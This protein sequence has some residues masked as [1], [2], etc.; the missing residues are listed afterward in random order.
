MAIPK[1]HYSDITTSYANKNEQG[2]LIIQSMI[3]MEQLAFAAFLTSFSQSFKSNWNQE[4]VY[5][6]ND[7][8]ATYQGTTRTIS[9]GFDIPAGTLLQAQNSL[10][11][12]DQLMKFLYPAYNN[13][14]HKRLQAAE[15]KNKKQ[16]K[17]VGAVISHAPLVKVRF[18]NLIKSSKPNKNKEDSQG[19]LGWMDGLEWTPALD[20]GV[21]LDGNGNMYPKVISL[22]FGFNVLHQADLGWNRSEPKKT[23]YKDQSFFPGPPA[24]PPKEKK[25][26]KDKKEPK[27]E[28]K[29]VTPKETKSNP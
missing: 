24:E 10:K 21:F 29:E 1:D 25:D 19:L 5:G 7:P 28:S 9:L 4:T 23:L 16:I 14:S 12:C 15:K 11:K 17:S 13:I 26:P 27:A 20:M 3:S 8:I 6:R 2:V 18:A 22:S